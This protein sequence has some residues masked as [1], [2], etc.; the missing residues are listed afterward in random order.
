MIK[1]IATDMDGTL[2]GSNGQISTK[3]KEA[4]LLAQEQGIE[5]V[6]ATGRSYLEAFDALEEAGLK[7]PVIAVNGA[8]V[9][10]KEGE[11][12]SSVSIDKKLAK[13][14]AKMLREQ[15][16]YFDV[17]TQDGRFTKEASDYDQFLN[18]ED[19]QIFKFLAY[20]FD[21]EKLETTKK[22]LSDFKELAISSS[23]QENLEINHFQAQKGIALKA[24]VK[25]KGI[26]LSETMALGDH[27]NDVSMFEL[28]G[29]AVAMGNASETLKSLCDVVT[30]TNDEHGVAKAILDILVY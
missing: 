11:V 24:Y 14:V 18:D 5:V 12:I 1:C 15:E 4:I 30:C 29:R 7:C 17:Y 21:S 23:G 25:S 26:D 3:N 27:M 19:S 16:I 9:Y 10:T 13:I 8:E 2:L 28:V 6:V 20:S 22:E